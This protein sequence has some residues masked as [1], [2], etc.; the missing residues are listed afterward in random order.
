VAVGDRRV[1]AVLGGPVVAD[2]QAERVG[3]AGRLAVQRELADPLAR[4]AD[5]PLLHPRVRDD[6]PPVV[7]D[8]VADELVDEV[9][10][11]R[12]DAGR[13]LLE[14]RHRLGQPV[15]ELHIAAAELAHELH[16][17]VARDAEGGT[18]ADHSHHEP[19]HV[20]RPR[21]AVDEVADEYGFP[22]ERWRNGH[23]GPSHRDTGILPVLCG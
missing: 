7:E 12:T 21:P 8:V 1:A 2:G 14:L 16:V 18:R 10:D 15:R 20:G 22:S 5:V 11:G 9:G 19:Q 4:A 17:V 13:R 3:L 23:S 6:E